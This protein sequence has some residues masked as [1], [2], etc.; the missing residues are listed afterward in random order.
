MDASDDKLNGEPTFGEAIDEFVKA[1]GAGD[2]I[3]K[4]NS[5][6][7][8]VALA[9]LVDDADGGMRA[10]LK[11]PKPPE[12]LILRRAGVEGGTVFVAAMDLGGGLG[13]VSKKPPP[14]SCGGEVIW[15]GAGADR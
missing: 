10:E 9:W 14:L 7:V 4:S 3:G 5:P 15:G 13:P 6:V 1:E 2:P 12:V 8:L 11:S